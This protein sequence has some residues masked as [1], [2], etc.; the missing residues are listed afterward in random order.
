MSESLPRTVFGS[1]LVFAVMCSAIAC[2]YA[3][4]ESRKLFTELQTLNADRDQ[5]EV[6]WGHTHIASIGS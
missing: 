1:V 5:M 4:H 6:E 2:V 3:K